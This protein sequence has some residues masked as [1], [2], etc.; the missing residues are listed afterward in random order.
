MG[1]GGFGTVRLGCEIIAHGMC[2]RV[3]HIGLCG[4]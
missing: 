4:T 3:A 2:V 1:A